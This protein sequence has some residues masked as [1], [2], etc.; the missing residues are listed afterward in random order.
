MNGDELDTISQVPKSLVMIIVT[1]MSWF[2]ITTMMIIMTTTMMRMSRMV[3]VKCQRR[4]LSQT[5]LKDGRPT[6]FHVHKCLSVIVII[7]TIGV[8][9]D[10]DANVQELQTAVLNSIT[11]VHRHSWVLL[12]WHLIW[13]G[14]FHEIWMMTLHFQKLKFWFNSDFEETLTFRW[15]WIRCWRKRKKN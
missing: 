13:L 15:H 10:F 7:V 1:I 12:C 6:F 4:P 5:G 2:M 3:T 8:N 9:L 11:K 14:T